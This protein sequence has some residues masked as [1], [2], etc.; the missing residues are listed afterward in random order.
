MSLRFEEISMADGYFLKIPAHG[1]KSA[2]D[3]H[4]L[5]FRQPKFL[6]LQFLSNIK[7]QWLNYPFK[8][9]GTYEA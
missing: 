5:D 7:H 6:T 4:S 8:A 1:D 3:S 2:S 9:F